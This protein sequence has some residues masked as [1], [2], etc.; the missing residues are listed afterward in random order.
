MGSTCVDLGVWLSKTASLPVIGGLLAAGRSPHA[1]LSQ[2]DDDYVKPPHKH[3]Q[4]QG[5]GLRTVC[6]FGAR[7]A[8]ITNHSNNLGMG[9]GI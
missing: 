4:V 1:D 6:S 7:K 8:V 2:N 9:R 5:T 3:G